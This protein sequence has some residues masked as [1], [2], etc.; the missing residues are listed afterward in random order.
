[1]SERIDRRRTD[2]LACMLV[3]QYRPAD[4]ESFP[5]QPASVLDL[6]EIG[7]R[8]R[9]AEEF[10]A[11]TP[12]LLRFDALLRDGVKNATL[13]AAAAVAWCHPRVAASH[14]VGLRF[15][16]PPAGLSEILSALDSP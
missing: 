15:G 10:A 7:C 14:E 8:L 3:V 9:I 16:G 2:R 13:E 5:W 1:M 12:L 11:G 6:T 4:A